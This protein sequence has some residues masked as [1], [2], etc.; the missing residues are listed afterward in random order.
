M[1]ASFVAFVFSV[2]NALVFCERS[3]VIDYE[4]NQFLKDGKPFRYV[5]GSI[6]YFRVLPEYWNDRLYKIR[7]AGLNTIQT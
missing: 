6:H 1:L 2:T 7:K 3:F 4:N 5:S